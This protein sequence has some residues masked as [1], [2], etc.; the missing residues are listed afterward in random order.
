MY[1]SGGTLYMNVPTEK[2]K[3]IRANMCT[4]VY[5]NN[6]LREHF[7]SFGSTVLIKHL[8]YCT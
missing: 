5:Y 8:T 6:N 4:H 2:D 1:S 7:I 3:C